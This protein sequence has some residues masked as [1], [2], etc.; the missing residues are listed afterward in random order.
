MQARSAFP[1]LV[2]RAAILASL[3][4][5]LGGAC[6]RASPPPAGAQASPAP[7]DSLGPAPDATPLPE[8]LA[9]LVQ[10]FK[11]DLDGMVDRRLIRV[12]TV[13]NPILYFVDKGRETG[14]T[15][16]AARAFEKQLNQKLGNKIITVHVILI[17]VARDQLI[18]HLLGGQGDIAAAELTV[19][20]ERKK[21]VDFS[22]PV[23]TGI[24]EVL[25]NGPD[26][27][28]VASLDELSGKEV[29]VRLSSS[30]AEHLQA[31]NRRF[32]AQ[33]KA[34]GL[35]VK[36]APGARWVGYLSA[37]GTIQY[38]N[39]VLA[40]FS[41]LTGGWKLP[42]FPATPPI[43]LAAT[44]EGDHVRSTLVVPAEVV[45]A[46]GG[47]IIEVRKMQA[48]ARTKLETTVPAL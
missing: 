15:C 47:Y 41:A 43:T 39:R 44:A 17:P 29:Y 27:P 7:D 2:V 4:L 10:P 33:G 12:L 13:Q 30:Y 21:Q 40:V 31:L 46:I 16:E 45:K 11:G 36:P 48:P 8:G 3:V 19:T 38:V 22:D 37:Q 6:K 20:P 5:L 18:P 32:K 26:A 1:S 25:V 28:P 42:D 23:A 34:P 14:I 24:T 35:D 9:P